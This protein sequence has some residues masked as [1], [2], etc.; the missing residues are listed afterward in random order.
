MKKTKLIIVALI[1]LLST[2]TVYA[3]M[4][5]RRQ[6]GRDEL[7][8]SI[9]KELNLT[10]EQ[11]DRL[12]ANRKMQ[13]E[14]MSQLMAAM[15]EKQVKLREQLKDPTVTRAAIKPLANE[16][17]SLQAQLI[18]SRI[19]GIFAVREILTPEQVTKFYQMMEK[20]KEKR[21]GLW[22]RWQQR[23]KGIPEEKASK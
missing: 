3:Q 10:K 12:V 15:K 8:G 17:K 7:K 19:N 18:E 11:E 1:V 23:Q 9:A 14:K 16:I 5:G 13:R 20:G 21:R 4:P 22:H 6:R 2:A